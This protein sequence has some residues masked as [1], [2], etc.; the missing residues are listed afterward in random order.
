MMRSGIMKHRRHDRHGRLYNISSLPLVLS[1]LSLPSCL[2]E[3][4]NEPFLRS[5]HLFPFPSI[6]F[7]SRY[8][9]MNERPS[10]LFLPLSLMLPRNRAS[11][12][13]RLLA[14]TSFRRAILFLLQEHETL[15]S[16]EGLF[17]LLDL[18]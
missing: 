13:S 9:L 11:D 16:P 3:P 7:S 1:S 18:R 5:M 4:A 6:R 12:R 2:T 17:I 8:N 14:L 10:I 15:G